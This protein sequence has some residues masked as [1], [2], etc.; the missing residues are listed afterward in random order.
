LMFV[1]TKRGADKLVLD[2]Q[3]EGVDAAAIHGDLRQKTREQALRDFTSGKLPLLVAT[4]VAARGIDVE[5]VDLVL[6]YDP[7]DDHKAYLHRSGRTARAGAKGVVVTLSLWDQENLVRLL[8]RRIGI[9]QPIVEVFSNDPRLA[10][11]AAWEPEE[12]APHANAEAMAVPGATR[13]AQARRVG[14]GNRG[15]R[16][17]R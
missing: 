7:P 6:H 17:R 13:L 15:G 12:R 4:D 11:L 2:L 16:G 10:D 9:S 14:G 5:G 3:R 1:R 8:Q